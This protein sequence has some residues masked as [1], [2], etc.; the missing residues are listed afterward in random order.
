MTDQNNC[1]VVCRCPHADPA[2]ELSCPGGNEQ[3]GIAL[4]ICLYG[5]NHYQ[6][7]MKLYDCLPDPFIIQRDSLMDFLID[8]SNVS[9]VRPTLL[10]PGFDR[11]SNIILTALINDSL[12]YVHSSFVRKNSAMG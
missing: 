10:K 6:T 1:A 2:H 5:V 11:I 9:A 8:K 3:V 7:W 4:D 12:R